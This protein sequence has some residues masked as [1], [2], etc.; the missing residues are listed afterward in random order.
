MIKLDFDEN[1]K[2]PEEFQEQDD[3]KEVGGVSIQMPDIAPV[4]I[5][6]EKKKEYMAGYNCVVT[7]DFGDEYHL[8][9]EER[10]A[11]S[12]YYEL[13]VKIRNMKHTIRNLSDYV[14]AMRNVITCLNAIASTNGAF[15]AKSFI[16][17]YINGDLKIN[18]L[19]IPKYKGKDRKN[20]SRE[21]IAEFI[22]SDKD[23][24]ELSVNDNNITT[25]VS[26]ENF[27]EVKKQV[28]LDGELEEILSRSHDK[29][30][31]AGVT[32]WFDPNLDDIRDYSNLALP[33]DKKDRSELLRNRPMFLKQAKD[34]RRREKMSRSLSDLVSDFSI[35]DISKIERYDEKHGYKTK[36][37][38]QLPKFNNHAK[39]PDKAIDKYISELE[40]YEETQIKFDYHGK[41]RTYDEIH[42]I[43]VKEIL[44]DAGYNILAF[45]SNDKQKKKMDKIKK[46]GKK[47]QKLKEKLRL[48]NQRRK[49]NMN[50]IG[51][52][53]SSI[54]K[55][56]K[57]KKK[58]KEDD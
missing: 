16:K 44:N 30:S 41:M 38:G 26:S 22:M 2:L 45:R 54:D 58:K 49:K 7:H 17:K 37:K 36:A 11:R 6:S 57:K 47:A 9:D 32:E 52:T 1:K 40:E 4:Y 15:S 48:I 12:R 19:T 56:K 21:Y 31:E 18:G 13:F 53:V 42:D 8:T 5:S 20:L 55:K 29:P 46:D 39:N 43:E 14:I 27:E 28:F 51:G 35:D 24:S 33:L 23:I 34:I 50:S 10:K 3:E 25:D